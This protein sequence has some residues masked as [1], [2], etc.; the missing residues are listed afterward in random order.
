LLD[1]SFA[2]LVVAIEK[3]RVIYQNIK[4]I[5]L[6][7]IT[8]NLTELTIVLVSL[9]MGALFDRPLGLLAVQILA[10]DLMGEM[11]PLAALAR[12]PPMQD[13]L[14]NKPRNTKDHILDM[15]GIKDML[16]S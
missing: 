2:T 11:F 1:D 4:K 12:D 14:S 9:L 13:V 6:S 5:T 10:I 3:G 7:C 16:A 15:R 8:T